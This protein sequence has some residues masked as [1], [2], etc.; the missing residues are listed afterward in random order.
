MDERLRSVAR[1]EKE[2]QRRFGEKV[3]DDDEVGVV[4]YHYIRWV[5]FWFRDVRAESVSGTEGY[6][7][8]LLNILYEALFFV[9][10]LFRF[11]GE[12]LGD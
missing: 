2:V 8:F 9:F 11:R 5:C 6:I 1:E 12:E 3:V 10:R 4:V 7:G